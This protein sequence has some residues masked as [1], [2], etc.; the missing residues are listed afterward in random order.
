MPLIY[1][2]MTVDGGKP[3]VG[4]TARSLGVRIPPDSHPDI[5]VDVEGNVHPR[6]G[7]MSVAR[8][9]RDLETHRIPRR[10]QDKVRDAVGSNRDACWGMGE[11]AFVTDTVADG[12][13]LTPDNPSSSATHGVVEPD[14][15]MSLHTFQENLVKTRDQ[16]VIDED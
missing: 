4:N 10:L 1:R 5:E 9:W 12:L 3:K 15:T 6:T 16:W 13:V 8:N 11:G 7:G 14:S 2:S